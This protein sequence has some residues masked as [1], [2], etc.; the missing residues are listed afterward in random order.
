MRRNWMN[1]ATVLWLGSMVAWADGAVADD[2]SG[3]IK[4][5]FSQLIDLAEA[6][7]E[8]FQP[9]PVGE[10]A[11]TKQRALQAA[12]RL[13]RALSRTQADNRRQW[14][15]YL[16][17]DALMSELALADTPDR[18]PLENTARRL[19]QNYDNLDRPLFTQLRDTLMAYLNALEMSGNDRLGEAYIAQL[20]RL[21]ERLAAYEQEGGPTHSQQIGALV[22]WLENARQA[23]ELVSAVRRTFRYPNFVARLSEEFVSQGVSTEVDELTDVEDCILGTAIFGKAQMRGHTKARLADHPTAANLQLV[24]DGTVNSDNVGYNRGVRIYSRGVTDV[25]ATKDV[26]VTAAGID[27]EGANARCDTLSTIDGIAAK[28]RMVTRL[29]WRQ[30]MRKKSTAEYIASRHAEQRV[31]KQMDERADQL[32]AQARQ[33]YEDHFRKPLLR[34]GE[35]PQDLRFRT[36]RSAL[37]LT[38][39]QAGAQQLAA[40]TPPPALDAKADLAVRVHESMVANMSRALLGGVVVTDERVAEILQERTGEVPE[41]LQIT[42]DSKRWSITLSPVDPVT[43]VFSGN[44]IRFAIRGSRFQLDS[45]V[46]RDTLEMSA[47]YTFEKTPDGARFVRQG[48]VSVEFPNLRGAPGGVRIAVRTVMREKFAALF[49]AEFNT[50]G[51][52]L[53]GRWEQVGTLHLE[54]IAADQGWLSLAW[55]AA[56]RTARQSEAEPSGPKLAHSN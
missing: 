37:T 51:L 17:W 52:N 53:P 55:L 2:P 45:T 34:R 41:A 35:F 16:G 9:Y 25:L 42:E 19:F 33:Q 1:A 32:L 44:T 54:Q 10:V 7:K 48:D 18:G 23:D 29:A 39:R 5:D 3:A 49:T 15:D 11:Q 40:P 31:S 27:S 46:L 26:F 13:E 22:G 21:K 38:M 47:V 56:S 50:T 43:A 30:T 8:R 4:S 36:T 6:H 20:D 14:H 12:K 28:S 24:L